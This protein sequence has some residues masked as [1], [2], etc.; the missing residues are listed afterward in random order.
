MF[1]VLEN[2]VL[3]GGSRGLTW[4]NFFMLN[5]NTTK[6]FYTVLLLIA[7]IIGVLSLY[8]CTKY[9]STSIYANINSLWVYFEKK[10]KH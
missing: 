10:L 5:L 9:Y 3:L 2:E 6:I 8:Q 7:Q 4:G 1:L